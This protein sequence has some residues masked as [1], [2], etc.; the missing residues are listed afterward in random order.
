MNRLT[1]FAILV[2]A[3]STP[4]S[5]SELA[6]LSYANDWINS[7]PLTAEDLQGKIV[8]VQ[9]WTY[10]CI[11][12]IRTVPYV[13]AWA[14]KYRDQ[15]LVVIGVHAPEFEFE[16]QVAN[17]RWGAKTFGVDYPAAIDNDF[18]I[19]RG[20]GNQYWPAL[21]LFDG[22]G[23][24][25]Y[26]HF[27]EGDYERS[28]AEIQKL[29]AE[30]GARG[31]E[32]KLVSITPRGAE[33]PA[34]LA[35]LKSPETY[36]GSER[37]DNRVSPDAR[38]RL[39]QWALKGDWAV[40]KQSAVLRTGDGRLAYRFHARD[41]NLVMAPGTGGHPVRFRILLD[42]HPLGTS[43]GADANQQGEGTI[44]EPRMYQLIRQ[45]GSVG[46]REFE[47]EFLDAGVEV[48]VFTFG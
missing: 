9:F 12:W 39:N 36:L 23:R 26:R 43:H 46:E 41:L 7:R 21:Y 15:G 28:E 48:F 14:Q 29:L 11:N 2:T 34:D 42:G 22:R 17:A 20:F 40:G 6:S 35:N 27:G 10:S 5:T 19:W 44:A 24:V 45:T 25:R 30:A 31:I 18:A 8:L 13:R 37:G 16:R 47:I 3:M 4:T 38:L 32:R 1:L 33:V